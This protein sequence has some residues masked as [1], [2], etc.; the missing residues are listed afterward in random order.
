M[1]DGLHA[2][3]IGKKRGDKHVHGGSRTRVASAAGPIIGIRRLGDGDATNVSQAVTVT[4]EGKEK[5]GKKET[6]RGDVKSKRERR[7]G[8]T[9]GDEREEVNP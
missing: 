1:R 9:A 6:R 4:E 5:T 3:R 2:G 7:T 8:K